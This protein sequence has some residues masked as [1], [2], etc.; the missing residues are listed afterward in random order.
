MKK[1]KLTH[2]SFNQKAFIVIAGD[3]RG[4]V[5]SLKLS[6]NLRREDFPR[7]EAGEVELPKDMI[8]YQVEKMEKL[9]QAASN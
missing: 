4:G 9:L 1:S 6:P 3:D 8:G 2:V 5:T 7:N